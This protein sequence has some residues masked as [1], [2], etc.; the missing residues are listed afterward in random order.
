MHEILPL[1]KPDNKEQKCVREFDKTF[2]FSS[3]KYFCRSTHQKLWGKSIFYNK[4][5][6][7]E[8]LENRGHNFVNIRSN[9]TKTKFQTN[10][11]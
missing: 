11:I 7:E 4:T 10:L 5:K 2:L 3:C 6:M 8:F 1:Q 9:F